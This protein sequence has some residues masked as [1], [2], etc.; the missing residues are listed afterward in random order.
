MHIVFLYAAL[1][2]FLFV[3]LSVRTLMIRKNL[4][5]S[6]GDNGNQAMLR[7]MR[8]HANFAEYVPLSLLLL[9]FAETASAPAVALH[10]LGALLLIGRSAHAW[11]VSQVRENYNFRVAGMLSTF[12]VLLCASGYL[13]Y[14]S[15]GV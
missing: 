5:I 2:G 8:V 7:A 13:L 14:R 1:L 4:R 11:G 6:V 10:A 9:Y 15:A 12:A 3:G